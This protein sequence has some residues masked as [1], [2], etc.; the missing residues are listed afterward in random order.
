MSVIYHRLYVGTFGSRVLSIGNFVRILPTPSTISP[1]LSRSVCL[2]VTFLSTGRML[3]KIKN[4]KN[5]DYI[6]YVCHQM[7][8]L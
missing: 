4:I 1:H 5:D 2:S 6:I 8:Q 3:A 7:A